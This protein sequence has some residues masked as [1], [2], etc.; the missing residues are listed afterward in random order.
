MA[1]DLALPWLK[2]L[3]FKRL[4]AFDNKHRHSKLLYD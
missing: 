4:R 1:S 2:L 3:A